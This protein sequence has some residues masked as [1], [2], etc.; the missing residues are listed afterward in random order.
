M[1]SIIKPGKNSYIFTCTNY[2]CQCQFSCNDKDIH[3]LFGRRY[4]KCPECN[5]TLFIVYEDEYED[6]K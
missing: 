3:T 1:I 4:I 2:E 6:K 5:K